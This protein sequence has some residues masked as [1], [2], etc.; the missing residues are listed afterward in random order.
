MMKEENL[1]GVEVTKCGEMGGKE[2]VT[3][4]NGNWKF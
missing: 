1:L 4:I 2:V 3:L